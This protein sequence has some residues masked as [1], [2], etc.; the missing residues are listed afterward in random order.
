MQ[1]ALI[2]IGDELAAGE[3]VDTNTAWLSRRLRAEGIATLE[4]RTVRDDEAAIAAAVAE[5][6]ARSDLLVLTGGLGPTGDD[7]TRAA[8]GAALA[9][10]RP[11][12]VDAGARAWIEAW[13][14]RH[15]RPM[16]VTNLR[17]AER[18]EGMTCLDNENG[19]APGL[20]GRLGGCRVFALPGP[21]REMIAMFERHVAPE[22]PPRADGGAM[23]TATVHAY[24]LG[25]SRAAERIADLMPRDRHPLV[26]TTVSASIL[27]ARIR[28]EGPA[29]EASRRVEADAAEVERRWHPYAFGGGDETLAAATGRLLSAL[30]RTLVTA[31]SCTGGLLA[32]TIVDVPGS[33][34]WYRGGWVT[35]ANDLKTG[36][37]D[38][39]AALIERHGAV[40]AEVA[41]AMALGAARAGA[42]D[43]ALAI[44]GVAGPDAD[45]KAV[46]TV[47]VAHAGGGDGGAVTVR[48]FLFP[49]DRATVRDR[50]AKSALQM[51]RFALLGLAVPPP[52]LWEHVPAGAPEGAA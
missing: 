7:L 23:V 22:L 15:G 42:A 1:A 21:P 4:H 44:T 46:G 40:S 45:G 52:L 31:E 41:R 14:G 35:Y 50:S 5:L 11:L 30:S 43:H 49:G 25:E 17:Q 51:L 36:C 47:H 10:G 33:S 48:R 13:Y 39:P 16:P 18:P 2:S 20:A 12:V 26:G 34:R 6:A 3:S 37:L 38:V 32:K 29:A 27:S 9:P 8:L 24:G 19:T 28:A